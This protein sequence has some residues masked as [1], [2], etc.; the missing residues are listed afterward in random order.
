MRWVK[1]RQQNLVQ[2]AWKTFNA[3]G[4]TLNAALCLAPELATASMAM[5]PALIETNVSEVHFKTKILEFALWKMKF[6]VNLLFL[7]ATII[8]NA[9]EEEVQCVTNIPNTWCD[10]GICRCDQFYD[11]NSENTECLKIPGKT[12]HAVNVK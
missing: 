4:M 1:Q 9:C 10:S 5:F 6:Y 2:N 11:P 7:A 8:G 3:R 12:Y